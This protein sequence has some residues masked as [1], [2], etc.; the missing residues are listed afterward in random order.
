MKVPK[1]REISKEIL[2]NI[3]KENIRG[4][5][6]GKEKENEEVEKSREEPK[7]LYT[8]IPEAWYAPLINRNF[9]APQDKE[10]K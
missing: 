3:P 7:R 2:E 4:R 6:T 9:G 5:P 10:K 1:E 8:N